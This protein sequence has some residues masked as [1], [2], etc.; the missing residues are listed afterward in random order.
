MS[1]TIENLNK[2]FG[3]FQ[4]LNNINLNVPTGKLTSLLG[5]SGCGKTT[6]LRIIAGLAARS[7]WSA[8]RRGSA[9]C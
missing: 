8:G 5:P 9:R 7:R 1:I 6:L 2:N 4:A 3:S